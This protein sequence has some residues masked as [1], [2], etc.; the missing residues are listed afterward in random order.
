M[1]EQI[2]ENAADV[3]KAASIVQ[4]VK[5]N[6]IAYLLAVL[7]SYQVGMLDKLI[8]YGTGVCA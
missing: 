6:N 2:V 7:I 8:T 4:H 1:D 3:T 5:E